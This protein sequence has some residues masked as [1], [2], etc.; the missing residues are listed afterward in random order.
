[1]NKDGE[2]IL[3]LN[4]SNHAATVIERGVYYFAPLNHPHLAP[5]EIKSLL[6]FISYEESYGRKTEIVCESAETLQALNAA[7]ANAETIEN[8]PFD[9]FIYTFLRFQ[10]QLPMLSA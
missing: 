6:D 5:Q 10:F 4:I 1:L 8:D 7:A 9:K 2:K 3:I